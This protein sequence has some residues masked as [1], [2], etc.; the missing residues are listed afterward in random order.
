MKIHLVM[1]ATGSYDEHHEWPVKA[2][3]NRELAKR[4][5][6]RAEARGKEIIQKALGGKEPVRLREFDHKLW[7][8]VMEE[9]KNEFDKYFYA[10]DYAQATKYF[11]ACEAIE[12]DLTTEDG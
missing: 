1:G 6:E 3:V 4:Y 11:V 10:D 8:K 5:A 7:C 12:V 9:E 2:F